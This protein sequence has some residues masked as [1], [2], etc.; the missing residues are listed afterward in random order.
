MENCE[1][2]ANKHGTNN[3]V[4]RL[5]KKSLMKKFKTIVNCRGEVSCTCSLQVSIRM[6]FYCIY[7]AITPF[8]F[9][10]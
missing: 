5:L 4:L 2:S 6:S 8:N 10:K 3:E 1:N 9:C 7:V